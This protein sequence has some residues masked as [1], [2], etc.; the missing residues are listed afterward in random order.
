VEIRHL[1]YFVAIADSG[2]F[3]RAATGMN[4]TQPALS[5]QMQ[6]LEQE[7]E[8]RLFSRSKRGVQLTDAGK[9]FLEDAQHILAHLERA[10][11][12]ARR[13]QS[14]KA[15]ALTIGM[16]DPFSWHRIV[17]ESIRVFRRN[18][19]DVALTVIVMHSREQLTAL[20]QGRLSGGFVLS[21]P[22]DE[23]DFEAIKVLADPVMVAVPNT[24]PFAQ[25][26]PKRLAELAGEDFFWFPRKI[27]PVYFDEVMQT[28][29]KNGLEPRML[30]GGM[31]DTAN[32]S[33]VAAGLGCTFVPSEA[34]HRKPENVVLVPISDLKV[35]LRM[36]FVW[37]SENSSQVL[38]NFIQVVKANTHRP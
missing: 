38:K 4:V 15:G 1:R 5:R 20:R 32:L 21:R 23:G 28:C 10:Q 31:S 13:V 6:D 27:N 24:S 29:Q 34:R 30:E 11:I 37:R 33:L 18:H 25:R 17:T 3:A 14:G 9:A 26:P 2:G 8:V 19:P 7:L 35:T 22:Q 12:R 36:E 16:P